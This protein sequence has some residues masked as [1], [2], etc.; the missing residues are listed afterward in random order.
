M[1]YIEKKNSIQV[2]N[3]GRKGMRE[4]LWNW[5]MEIQVFT[6]WTTMKTHKQNSQWYKEQ[7]LSWFN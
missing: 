1:N 3:K 2:V 4:R 6:V 5:K 7:L